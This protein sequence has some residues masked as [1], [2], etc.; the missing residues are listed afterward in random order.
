MSVSSQLELWVFIFIAASCMAVSF[1]YVFLWPLT[2]SYLPEVTRVGR[3]NLCRVDL[4]IWYTQFWSQRD[5]ADS[6]PSLLWW[7]SRTIKTW[8]TDI[9]HLT[10]TCMCTRNHTYAHT[11]M[12]THTITYSSTLTCTNMYTYTCLYTQSHTYIHTHMQACTPTMHTQKDLFTLSHMHAHVI[13]W[14]HTHILMHTQTHSLA[15]ACTHVHTFDIW[16]LL[17]K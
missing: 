3:W 13:T 16:I 15:Y 1:L 7:E 5:M 2:R 6:V 10:H 17:C 4:E 8:D 12:H 9:P 11:H 14:T